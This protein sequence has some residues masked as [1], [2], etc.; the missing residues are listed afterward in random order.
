MKTSNAPSQSQLK[1]HS[2]T[3]A[4]LSAKQLK[5]VLL[6]FG[7]AKKMARVITGINNTPG[8]LTHTISGNLYCNNVSDIR[9]KAGSRLLKHGLKLV[10]IPQIAN[11]P[12]TKSYHWYLCF[13][14]EV[15]YFPTDEKAANDEAIS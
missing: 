14:G 15:E 5:S 12:L 4:N 1:K 8:M 11:N 13:I 7:R 3:P 2:I 10:C 9:Q 6:S